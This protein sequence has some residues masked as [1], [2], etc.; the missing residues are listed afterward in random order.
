[1][2]EK[3]VDIAKN[4]AAF[5]NMDDIHQ[6]LHDKLLWAIRVRRD[7]AAA[8]VP[9]WE[10]LRDLASQIKEHTLTHLDKYVEQF[11]ENAEKNGMTVHWAG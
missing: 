3:I 1:M 7:E 6:P 9:E 10:E 8:T 11:A 2:S 4:S 5:I